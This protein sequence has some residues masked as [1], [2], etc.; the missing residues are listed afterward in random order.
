MM[1]GSGDRGHHIRCS[2][3]SSCSFAMVEHSKMCEH[4]HYHLGTQD[5]LPER[6]SEAYNEDDPREFFNKDHL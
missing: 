3:F 5:V 6:E 1:F 2:T 4:E